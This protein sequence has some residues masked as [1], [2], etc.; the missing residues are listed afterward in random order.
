MSILYDEDGFSE[1]MILYNLSGK[2]IIYMLHF[3]N[4]V[5]KIKIVFI[6]PF[7]KNY[8]MLKK[9]KFYKLFCIFYLNTKKW[10]WFH[11]PLFLPQNNNQLTSLIKWNIDILNDVSIFYTER[12]TQN[13]RKSN[14]ISNMKKK[15]PKQKVYKHQKQ[16]PK[17]INLRTVYCAQG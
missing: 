6:T 7:I 1:N 14:D 11:S 4:S 13:L 5:E 9:T 2:N 3:C 16:N 12:F 10:V 17:T 15:C 8:T